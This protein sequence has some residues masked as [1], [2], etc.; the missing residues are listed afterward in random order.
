[1][2]GR[3]H[4]GRTLEAFLGALTARLFPLRRRR[5]GFRRA[6]F[7]R[8]GN[9]PERRADSDYRQPEPKRAGLVGATIQQRTTATSLPV[10]TIGNVSHLRYSRQYADRVIDKLLDALLRIDALRGTGRIY[11]P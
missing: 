8:L 7:R 4:A 6:R 2:A 10:F 11:L 5:F 3:A 9:M 1:M